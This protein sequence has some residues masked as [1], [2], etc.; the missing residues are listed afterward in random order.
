MV[1]ISEER[2]VFN[3]TQSIKSLHLREKPNSLDP[4]ASG[5]M[6][7]MVLDQ[8]KSVQELTIQPRVGQA[9]FL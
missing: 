7:E 8:L 4:I 2:S 5:V 1:T 9:L 6:D 3:Q